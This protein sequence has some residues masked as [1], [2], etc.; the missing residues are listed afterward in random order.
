MI[1]VALG[2]QKLKKFRL[3]PFFVLHL[4]IVDYKF[5]PFKQNSLFSKIL[6]L[7]KSF[8]T[9]RSC[10]SYIMSRH[11]AIR[12]ICHV[13]AYHIVHATLFISY[14]ITPFTSRRS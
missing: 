13:M 12:A 11:I 4:H 8:V 7:A 6:G 5:F 10:H 3:S 14:D 2:A 1:L 9:R